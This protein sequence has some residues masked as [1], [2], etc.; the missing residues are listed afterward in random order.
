M[1]DKDYLYD[2]LVHDLTGPLSVIATTVNRLLRDS[3]LADSDREPLER[4]QRNARKAQLLLHEILEV[5]RAEECLYSRDEFSLQELVSDALISAMERVQPE[6]T[7]KLQGVKDA[8][9]ISGILAT[10]GIS[11]EIAGRY[12]TSPLRHD[13]KKIRQILENLLSN[14][15]KY[16]KKIMA[17][18]VSGEGDVVICVSDDGPGIPPAQQ[19]DVFKRFMQ[20]STHAKPFA[21]LGL[22]LFCVKELVEKM[23]GEIT[24][25]SREGGGTTFTVRVPSLESTV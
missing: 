1:K 24:I 21:G 3:G 11:T 13:K 15:L 9:E 22:G 4:V 2:L 16:R 12:K 6:T 20:L 25:S 18:K 8:E 10:V 14:A 17:L 23:G 7:R 5:A 19:E